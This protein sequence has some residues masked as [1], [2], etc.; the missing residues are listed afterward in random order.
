MCTELELRCI[1]GSAIKVRDGCIY[2]DFEW[3]CNLVACEWEWYDKVLCHLHYVTCSNRLEYV[4][5][6]DDEFIWDDECGTFVKVEDNY[7]FRLK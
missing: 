6:P 3:Y 1:D 7:C 4:G 2:I 5:F